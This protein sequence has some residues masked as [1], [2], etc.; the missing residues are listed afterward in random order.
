MWARLLA[1]SWTRLV[2][3]LDRGRVDFFIT[4]REVMVDMAN[5]MESLAVSK[6]TDRSGMHKCNEEEGEM[7]KFVIYQQVQKMN[8]FIQHFLQ[9]IADQQVWSSSHGGRAH[10]ADSYPISMALSF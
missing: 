7:D 6:V 5:L 3:A 2:G 8:L 1:S 4:E 10:Y 9:P